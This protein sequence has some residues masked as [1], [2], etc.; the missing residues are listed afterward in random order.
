MHTF[1]KVD[2]ITYAIG[3]WID[4]EFIRLFDVRTRLHAIQATSILNGGSGV[5]QFHP[6]PFAVIED[7][8]VGTTS[9]P[10]TMLTH[11]AAA[12]AGLL[13]KSMS[14]TLI[15][16]NINTPAAPT[17]LLTFRDGKD[18]AGAI[19]GVVDTSKSSTAGGMMKWPFKV[20]LFV[21]MTGNAD[22]TIISS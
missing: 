1:N 21:V 19:M 20:G 13:I 4:L 6:P 22:V 11:L 8:L 16:L 14:G 18:V 7:Y 15:G 17:G 2:D 12:T 10:A 9:N 5:D 3:Y